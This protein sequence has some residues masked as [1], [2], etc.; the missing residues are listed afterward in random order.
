MFLS[1][2]AGRWGKIN[3][4]KSETFS[5]KEE[6]SENGEFNC[7]ICRIGFDIKD[8]YMRHIEIHSHQGIIA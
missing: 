1:T 6:V 3:E 5:I 2:G 7:D 4:I 8:D